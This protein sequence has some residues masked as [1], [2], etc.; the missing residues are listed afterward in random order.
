MMLLLGI[1]PFCNWQHAIYCKAAMVSWFYVNNVLLLSITH[2]RVCAWEIEWRFLVSH[3]WTFKLNEDLWPFWLSIVH[4]V[5]KPLCF[6]CTLYL[7]VCFIVLSDNILILRLKE[8]HQKCPKEMDA[9]AGCMY[10]YTNEFDFC[11]K[12]QQDF[13]SACPVSE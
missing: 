1:W 7:F 4:F 8:L 5:V 12:E 9:Y 3:L 11:R 6:I 10:Y 2:S 13:E